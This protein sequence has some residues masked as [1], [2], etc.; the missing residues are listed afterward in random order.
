[1]FTYP[2][3]VVRDDNGTFLVSFPDVQGAVTFGDTKEEAL[4]RGLDALET[5][6]AA[7]IADRQVLPMP[8]A[9]RKGQYPVSLPPLSAAKVELYMVMHRAGIRKAE[10]ARRLGWHGPQI[11]R[12]LD[13]RHASRLEQLEQAFRVLGKRLDIQVLDAA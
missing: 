7:M 4:A 11:D 8:S 5:M 10:L 6:L 3:T 1:M 9:L 13:L 2:A 12:L